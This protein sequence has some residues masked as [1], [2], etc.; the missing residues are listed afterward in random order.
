MPNDNRRVPRGN[1]RS[2]APQKNQVS[3]LQPVTPPRTAA[4]LSSR[5]LGA[6][7]EV[8]NGSLAPN[9]GNTLCRIARAVVV[10]EESAIKHGQIDSDGRGY[11]M[12]LGAPTK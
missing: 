7:A 8:Y 3:V 12:P 6:F 11:V 1:S 9:Q 10:V 2:R 4:E 5:L